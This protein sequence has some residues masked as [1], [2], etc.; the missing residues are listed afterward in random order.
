MIRYQRAAQRE[1]LRLEERFSDRY[2]A[3]LREQIEYTA[4]CAQG[5]VTLGTECIERPGVFRTRHKWTWIFFY[6][7]KNGA[8][9]IINFNDTRAKNGGKLPVAKRRRKRR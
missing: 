5:G 2:L 4:E 3:D 9:V 1:L 7:Q 6:P 8:T